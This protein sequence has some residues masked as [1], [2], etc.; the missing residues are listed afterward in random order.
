MVLNSLLGVKAMPRLRRTYED[1]LAAALTWAPFV[2]MFTMTIAVRAALVLPTEPRANWVF[3]ITEHDTARV[4]QVGAVVRS[5]IRLGVVLPLLILFPL[6]W[7]TFHGQ[8]IASTAVTLAAGIALVEIG[9]SEWRRLPFT[10]SYMPGKRFVGL[11]LIIGIA[12][13]AGFASIGSLLAYSSRTHPIGA[14]WSS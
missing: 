3:R 2:L 14:L 1:E 10:C 12:S 11:T 4:D 5:M 7:A 9:M 6:Q 13:F 8:A